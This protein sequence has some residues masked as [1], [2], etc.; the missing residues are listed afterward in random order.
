MR[1]HNVD[2][3]GED[4][5]S[6]GNRSLA[7]VSVLNIVGFLFELSGGII[8][9]SVALLSDA[10]HMLFDAF[11][12]VIAYTS[13]LLAE[14]YGRS[15]WSYGSHRIETLAAFINGILLIPMVVF[16]LWESYQR[17]LSPLEIGTLGTIVVATIG[18]AVNLVS[19]FILEENE[20]SLNEKGAFYHLLG[21]VGGSVAVI[22]STIVIHIL[23][24][25]VIDPVIASLI[26]VLIAGSAT[27]VLVGSSSI[28]LHRNPIDVDSVRHDI[29]NIQGVEEVSDLHVWQMCSQIRVATTHIEPDTDVDPEV[30][31]DI[32]HKVHQTLSEYCV[33]HATVEVCFECKNKKNILKNI[34][35]SM[36]QRISVRRKLRVLTARIGVMVAW[37]S[38]R[39]TC[40]TAKADVHYERTGGVVDR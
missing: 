15:S 4:N 8:F 35:T 12:Y 14:R 26:A 38:H 36:S 32:I 30:R 20:M 7:I 5:R 11:A 39:H 17:F 31:K 18:L 24:I 33:D 40:S 22:V 19:V 37:H 16:I 28:F 3:S 34:I 29:V 13:T 1:N 10:V 9:G 6:T 27:K 2:K 25:R 23:G 21:D